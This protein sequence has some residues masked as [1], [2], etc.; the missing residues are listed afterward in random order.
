MGIITRIGSAPGVRRLVRRPPAP[1]EVRE[2]PDDDDRTPLW[3]VECRRE[4]LFGLPRCGD[5][6]GA[7]VSAE[8]L[9]RRTGALPPPAGRGPSDW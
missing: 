3:C 6:G 5:C 8:E 7:A 9:A 2:S 4:V 1:G